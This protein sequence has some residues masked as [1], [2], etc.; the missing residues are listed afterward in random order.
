MDADWW[1][2]HLIDFGAEVA[3]SAV[4]GGLLGAFSK[5]IKNVGQDI[6]K[7]GRMKQT[8]TLSKDIDI[9]LDKLSKSDQNINKWLKEVEKKPALYDKNFQKIGSQ[10]TVD[11]ENTAFMNEK[12]PDLF[13]YENKQ[14]LV[15]GDNVIDI[16]FKNKRALVNDYIND[17]FVKKLTAKEKPWD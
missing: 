13:Q 17:D 10:I 9:Y 2:D 11:M 8:G 16:K 1:A 14:T 7:T 5:N 4:L 3:S 15:D 12:Y 6:I